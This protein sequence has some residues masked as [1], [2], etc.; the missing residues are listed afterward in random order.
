MPE[1]PFATWVKQQTTETL[2]AK[3]HDQADAIAKGDMSPERQRVAQAQHMQVAQE[4][5]RRRVE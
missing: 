2:L 5:Q 3:A 4:L 1:V